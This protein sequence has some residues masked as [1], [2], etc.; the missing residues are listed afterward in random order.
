V[1]YF[2]FLAVGA[3]LIYAIFRAVLSMAK[4]DGAAKAENDRLKKDMDLDKKRADAMM[5]DQTIAQTIRDLI[6]GKF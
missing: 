2:L 5:K 4:D 3:G 1:S 6:N